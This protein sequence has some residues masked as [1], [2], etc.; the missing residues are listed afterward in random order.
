MSTNWLLLRG[1]MREQRHWEGF[2]A[3]LQQYFPDD[4]VLLADL[5]GFGREVQQQSPS[6]IADI[7]DE[8]RMR[9]QAERAKGPL[10]L[11]TLSLGGMVAI[12]WASRYPD[13]LSAVVL[14]NSSWQ[15]SAP[16]ITG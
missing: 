4:G 2:P 12:D 5:P 6:R 1:L 13:E 10:R 11:L 8:L 14:I 9:W 7:T 15:A 16:F 3:R